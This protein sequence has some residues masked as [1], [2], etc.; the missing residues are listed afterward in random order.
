MKLN[1]GSNI[2]L[3]GVVL[4]LVVTFTHCKQAIETTQTIAEEKPADSP[5][6]PQFSPPT[7]PPK[8]SEPPSVLL[9]APAEIAIDESLYPPW[10]YEPDSSRQSIVEPENTRKKGMTGHLGRSPSGRPGPSMQ[11]SQEPNIWSPPP[12][13]LSPIPSTGRA[14][15]PTLPSNS[16]DEYRRGANSSEVGPYTHRAPTYPSRGTEQPTPKTKSQSSSAYPNRSSQ[17][18]PS[19]SPYA[20]PPRNFYRPTQPY[21]ITPPAWQYTPPPSGYSGYPPP[22]QFRPSAPPLHYNFP[23]SATQEPIPR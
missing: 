5:P 21:G 4:V 13:R 9:Q 12:A 7:T 20:Q 10:G 11:R 1:R 19:P 18:G 17:R 22:T 8:R 6:L 3:A 23:Y 2:V 15:S 16:R 14:T